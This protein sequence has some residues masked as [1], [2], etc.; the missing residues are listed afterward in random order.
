MVILLVT[1]FPFECVALKEIAKDLNEPEG[2]LL[3]ILNS[4][5]Q[6]LQYDMRTKFEKPMFRRGVT[7]M[8]DL[9][10]GTVVTGEFI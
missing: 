7:S 1:R 3:Q 9:Q 4:L 10:I 6:P 8:A 5:A 2:K